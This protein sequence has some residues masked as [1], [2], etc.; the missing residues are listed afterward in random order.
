[1]TGYNCMLGTEKQRQVVAK[2][3]LIG[4]G[5]LQ[6][7]C[8]LQFN[9]QCM[10][11]KINLSAESTS[12]KESGRDELQKHYFSL[13]L[14]HELNR[15][16]VLKVYLDGSFCKMARYL[17]SAFENEPVCLSAALCLDPG[18]SNSTTHIV[19]VTINGD[20]AENT[21]PKQKLGEFSTIYI[22]ILTR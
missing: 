20:E 7:N 2:W 14:Q 9:L 18:L 13:L 21:R 5:S 6:E 22:G 1:M 3:H 16:V 4:W 12:Y 19:S 15:Y 10:E 17:T 8:S 11:W